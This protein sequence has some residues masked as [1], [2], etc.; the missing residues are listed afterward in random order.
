M[1]EGRP[2]ES[3]VMY[4]NPVEVSKKAIIFNNHESNHYL[5]MNR[6]QEA[7]IHTD[8]GVSVSIKESLTQFKHLILGNPS[9][10]FAII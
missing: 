7:L 4:D 10:I 9:K 6:F 5:N 1:I 2:R 3:L 8:R